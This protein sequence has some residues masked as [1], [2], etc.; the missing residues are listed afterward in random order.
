MLTV[1]LAV[2]G[3]TLPCG[4]GDGLR[5]EA[6]ELAG[7]DGSDRI[8]GAGGEEVDAQ[9]GERGAVHFGELHFQQNFLRADRTEGKHVD[10][11]L[12]IGGGQF[13]GA[14]GDVFGGNVAGENDGG[15]RRRDRDLLFGKDAMLFFGAGADIDIDAQIEAARAFQFVPDEQRNFARS[16]A[17]DENLR[18]SDDLGIG[19]RGV[20]DRDALEALGRIN[21][22]RLADHDAQAE[23]NLALGL[24][25]TG[26]EEWFES[27]LAEPVSC[28]A[29]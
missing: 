2:N 9:L 11:I 16:A 4:L 12:G 21:E 7:G 29:G 24:A 1:S 10:N 25:P 26:A 23:P 17:M 18:G 27:W 19:D 8:A 5:A 14:L 20:G 28:G 3:R 15:A 6:A 13:S 22:Q